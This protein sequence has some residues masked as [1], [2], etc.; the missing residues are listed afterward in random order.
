[1]KKSEIREMIKEELESLNESWAYKSPNT[2]Y[3]NLGTEIARSWKKFE[4]DDPET[5]KKRT[6]NYTKL[7][8]KYDEMY[9]LLYST[10]N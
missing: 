3:A 2:A 7:Q 9:N 4:K 10:F 6:K 8:K 5:F 1:M